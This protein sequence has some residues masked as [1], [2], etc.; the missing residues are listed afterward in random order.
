MKFTFSRGI[1]QQRFEGLLINVI[2]GTKLNNNN[3][4]PAEI[5]RFPHHFRFGRKL[6]RE[7]Q[8]SPLT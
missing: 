3:H 6:R 8:P 1:C 2:G 5:E 4:Y 7:F